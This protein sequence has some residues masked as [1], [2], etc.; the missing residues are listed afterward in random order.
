M[1]MQP[2]IYGLTDD[3][4][5]IV[6][7]GQ[8]IWPYDRTREHQKRFPDVTWMVALQREFPDETADKAERKWIKKLSA[9]GLEL[10][11]ITRNWPEREPMKRL[12]IDIRES[13]HRR[14]KVGCAARG[15]DI[16]EVMRQLLEKEFPE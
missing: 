16:A 3:Y 5:Q 7:V 8:S 2:I 13:L 9:D 15:V 1:S 11:N 14:V 12:T 10:R 6:Y 4:G